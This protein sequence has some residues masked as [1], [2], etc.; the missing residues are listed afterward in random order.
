[1]WV[2]NLGILMNG[3]KRKK[4][5]LLHELG[6]FK[7]RGKSIVGKNVKGIVDTE[8]ACEREDFLLPE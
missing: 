7:K 8:V 3:R 6:E 1:M 2:Y 4:G 5:K